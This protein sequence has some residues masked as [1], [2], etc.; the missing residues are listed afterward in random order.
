[1][2]CS[3]SHRAKHL[4]NLVIDTLVGACNKRFSEEAIQIA[5]SVD[6][7]LKCDDGAARL[8]R[9]YSSTLSIEMVIMKVSLRDVTLENLRA[10]A[11]TGFYPNVTKVLKLA[12][13]L[14]VGTATCI[15]SDAPGPQ[16]DEDNYGPAE[17]VLSL[18]R[19][20]HN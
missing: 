14:P 11:L 4:L 20:G 9:Q 15:L 12:L 6:A 8:I 16:L 17:P 10:A 13:Y 19:E 18:H 3:V 1:M 2:A 7:V 5:K